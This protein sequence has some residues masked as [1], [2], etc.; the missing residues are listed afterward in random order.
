MS[1]W[2]KLTLGDHLS[3][4]CGFPFSSKSFNQEKRGLPL[5][6]IR[7]LTT[8]EPDTYYEGSFDKS[9]IISKD[10]VLIGMDGEFNIIK[11]KK[12]PALLNQ[13]VL[14][15][16][17]KQRGKIDRDYA[18]YF[19]IPF[20]KIVEDKTPATTVKHLSVFDIQDASG[21]FPEDIIEQRKIARVLT[22]VDEVI[23]RAKMAIAKYKAIK[24]GM[25]HDLF[26]RGIDLKTRKLRPKYEDAPKL[27]KKTELGWVP[28]EWDVKPLEELSIGGLKNGYFKKPEFVGR[29]YKLI[30]VTDLYQSFGID[31]NHRAV[32]RVYATLPDL[33][34]YE[35]NVGDIFFT[36]S[37]L[38]LEGIAH[39]NIVLALPEVAV[40]EC[41]VM[42][43]RPNTHLV[44]P[45]FL[46]SYCRSHPARKFFMSIAKQ[47]TMATISQPDVEKL[48]VPVPKQVIEQNEIAQILL[49]AEKTIR[50]EVQV[51][52]KNTKL[53]RGLMS[54]LLTGLIR[55]NV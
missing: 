34:K 53:K 43:L 45:T 29:G 52:Q 38:V 5:L 2:Q 16:D 25:M 28:K 35:A 23:E 48:P 10:D 17:E 18:Y 14:R 46:A 21:N 41:H 12:T 32:E 7:D 15:L 55:V 24:Q 30:N 11:W 37:S 40:Y 22:T 6:R 13:R 26:T 3:C 33:S 49:R 31:V 54:D 39:C 51:L 47:V 19:L 1:D 8:Q 50:K 9:F 27:Y 44:N 42:R 20:L 4:F 36:R